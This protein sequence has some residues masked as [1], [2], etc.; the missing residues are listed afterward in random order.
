MKKI[1]PFSILIAGIF[2]PF[3]LGAQSQCTTTCHYN[4][5]SVNFT[6][7]TMDHTITTT[8]DDGYNNTETHPGDFEGTICGGV[9]PCS[10][11]SEA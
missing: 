5:C 8:C 4:G 9:T 7:T 3:N 6:Q 1:I 10:L 11:P 2:M